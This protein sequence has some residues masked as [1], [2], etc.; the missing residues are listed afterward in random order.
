VNGAPQYKREEHGTAFFISADGFFLTAGHVVDGCP[1]FMPALEVMIMSA[2]GLARMPVLFL[3]RHPTADVA[4]GKALVDPAE[5]TK[6]FAMT[7]SS[8]RLEPGA[9]VAV[10]GAA[11]TETETA[12]DT[13][14]R[15]S[16]R[17]TFHGPDYFEGEVLDYLP[18]GTSIAPR[19]PTYATS[20][21][22]PSPVFPTLGGAS[23]GPL[24]APD[25]IDVHGIFITGSES[26][27]LCTDILPILDWE[28]F[29]DEF[30]RARTLR[31]AA[32]LYP[33]SIKVR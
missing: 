22:P 29:N 21:V 27:S 17:F 23:G 7:L 16:Q 25:S 6:P 24:V 28:V 13:D 31:E 9:D 8:R 1:E 15:P 3:K 26:Y 30:P 33:A 19:F 14:G 32:A 10:L 12:F 20:I 11:R 5:P 2:F 18:D 4:L